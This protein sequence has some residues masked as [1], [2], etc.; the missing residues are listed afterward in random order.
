MDFK[1]HLETAWSETLKNIAMLILITLVALAVGCL[2][3][4]ILAPV[5]MAGFT[6]AVVLMMRDGREPRIEDLFS[7]MGL[8]L[9]LLGFSIAVAIAIAVGLFMLVL[10]GL[11]VV[12]AL[13]FSC[14]YLLPLMTERNLG[15]GDAL[16]ASWKMAFDD[17]LADHIVMVILF[18][19]L[20]SIGF[21][22]FVGILLTG[23][24]AIVF[25]IS[26]YL[27]KVGTTPQRTE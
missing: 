13:T 4:G 21:S 7:Q 9:P 6:H 8:F 22:V 17:S 12:F 5:V 14:L 11:A 24:F 3:L 27:E 2:T 15:L 18:I 25:L 19:G 16:K 23:P 26:V 10:P 20:I 1:H